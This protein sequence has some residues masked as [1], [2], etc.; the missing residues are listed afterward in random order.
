MYKLTEPGWFDEVNG[1]NVVHHPLPDNFMEH[2]GTFQAHHGIEMHRQQGDSTDLSGTELARGYPIATFNIGN[3]GTINQYNHMF[4]YADW[5]G[6]SVSEYAYGIEHAGTT[7]RPFTPA[8]LKSSH[9][10]VAALIEITD[11]RFGEVIPVTWVPRVSVANYRTVKGIWNHKAVDSGPLNENNHQ[12]LMEGQTTTAFCTSVKALL[13][14][15]S[16]GPTFHGTLLKLGTDAPD[17]IVWKRRMG[18]LGLFVIHGTN[19]GPYY[20]GVIESAT[21]AFQKKRKLKQDGI[22]GPKTWEA[23]WVK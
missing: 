3:D 13:G 8:Q 14:A 7:G 16:A 9:A 19:D 4:N 22:V 20:G 6:D 1:V 18:A 5:H 17:V 21:K 11:D 10:L 12:D 15:Q 2:A 23:A